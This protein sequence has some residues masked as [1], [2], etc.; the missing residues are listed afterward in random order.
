MYQKFVDL[1]TKTGKT[2]AEVCRET[3]ISESTMS[4]WKN[5]KNKNGEDGGLSA[6]NLKKLA[7]YFKMPIEYF[8]T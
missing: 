1:L 8:L 2:V 4:N 5:R 3:G 7:D 6:E